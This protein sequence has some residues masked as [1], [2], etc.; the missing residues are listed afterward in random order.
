MKELNIKPE[1]GFWTCNGKR[2]CDCSETEKSMIWEFIKAI[3]KEME[4]E[5]YLKF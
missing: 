1:N 3:K 2:Y 4:L 5:N